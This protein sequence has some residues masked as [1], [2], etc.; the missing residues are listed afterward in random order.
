MKIYWR[1]EDVAE[2]APLAPKER[3]RVHDLCLRRHFL[4]TRPT[5]RSVLAYI[6]FLSASISVAILGSGLLARVVAPYSGWCSLEARLIG[7]MLG[8]F[9]FTRIAIPSL[10]SHYTEFIESEL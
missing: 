6:A 5:R 2:L 8:W 1:L 3:R 4:Y 10:R 7:M 9:L